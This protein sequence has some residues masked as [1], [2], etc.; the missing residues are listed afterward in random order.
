M[1]FWEKGLAGSV[2]VLN[3]HITQTLEHRDT[4]KSHVNLN[5][6]FVNEIDVDG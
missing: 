6:A 3:P 4:I 2:I 5:P 1:S